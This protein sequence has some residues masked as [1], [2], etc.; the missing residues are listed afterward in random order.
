M[1]GFRAP[2]TFRTFRDYRAFGVF[3]TARDFVR[4]DANGDQGRAQRGCC[5]S[6]AHGVVFRFPLRF[7][8]RR[9]ADEYSTVP[10]DNPPPR[11]LAATFLAS[12]DRL[13]RCPADDAP[14]AVFVGRSN[15]G[16]S[17]ALNRLAGQR[18]LARVSKTPGRTQLINFFTVA[19]GGRL[20]DLPGYGYARA[21]K[22]RREAWGRA[23]DEYL[24]ARANVVG[25]VLVM[26]IR[27]PLRE[28]DEHM[29]A[30]IEQSGKQLLALLSKAD[31]LK[32]GAR[33]QA[34]RSV[35]AGMPPGGE[36]VAFSA[37]TGLGAVEAVATLREWLEP[38]TP[39]QSS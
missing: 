15:A 35:A 13:A 10:A 9:S 25:V 36:V 38:A 12:A 27:H 6:R 8:V 28:A 3:R 20:V 21:S 24:S 33:A 2:R 31:K 7:G 34:L 22:T 5:D 18:R 19:G 37:L 17:S 23:V 16:K 14:E 30:W 26:D 4:Y 32:R 39:S 29:I 1:C 11:P